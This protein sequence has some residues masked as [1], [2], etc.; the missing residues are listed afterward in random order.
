MLHICT[1]RWGDKY[2]SEYVHRLEAGVARNL[3]QEHRFCVFRPEDEDDHLTKIKGCFARLRMF[4]PEWQSTN[5]M[6][7]GDRVVCMDLDSIV[8]KELDPLFN[9]ADN[10]CI[11]TGANS[12]NPCPYNGS[13]WM[14][15]AG[16][17]PDVWREF[18]LEAAAK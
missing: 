3:K 18:N 17:R 13:L 11:L 8:I 12:S 5:G 1:W 7:P 2:G 4:D 16:Y 14:F 9:R 10:F 6:Q 15:R